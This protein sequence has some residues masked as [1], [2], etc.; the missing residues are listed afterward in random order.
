M[1]YVVKQEVL[2]SREEPENKYFELK[3]DESNSSEEK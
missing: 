3:D 1:K 2:P